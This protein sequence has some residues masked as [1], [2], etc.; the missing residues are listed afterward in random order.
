MD[1]MRANHAAEIAEKDAQI[2]E[3]INQVQTKDI[4]ISGIEA[5]LVVLEDVSQ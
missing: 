5:K 3:L 1:E 2:K 4:K